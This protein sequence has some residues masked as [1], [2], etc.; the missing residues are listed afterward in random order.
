MRKDLA[1]ISLLW[2]G[3]LAAEASAQQA[4]APVASPPAA[5]GAEVPHRAPPPLEYG[6]SPKRTSYKAYA[7]PN[8]PIWRLSEI[9]AAHKGQASWTQA[10]VRGGDLE[11]D[12]HQM[13]P[14]GHTETVK[15][16]DNRTGLIVWGGQVKVTIEGQEPFV[17][18]KGFEIDVPFRRAF[19]LEAMGSEPALWLEVH[20]RGDL[21]IYPLDTHPAKPADVA[22][23]SY[24]KRVLQ[25]GKGQWDAVNRPWL[26]YQKDVVSGG[27]RAGAFIA[28]DHMFINNIR[29]KGQ[30]LPP[31]ANLGHFH[32]GYDEFWFIMEGTVDY[33]I[34]GVPV[35]SSHAGDV[36]L[37]LQG[38]WHRASFG[39]EPGSMSTRVAI[40]PYP[41]GLH[42]Y[43]MESAGRQ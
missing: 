36:V 9:L 43:T 34:E 38:H 31:P 19:T 32:F 7:E 23:F 20:G 24:E 35:F 13:A 4:P 5:G 15:Y 3:F 11:A 6:W 41:N 39:G 33:Q 42:N 8:R 17:A 22:G 1:I 14:G 26:D 30:P 37:A 28:S 18:G 10:I 21:P 25:G 2:A 12:W 40:N 16:P 29:G 27:A